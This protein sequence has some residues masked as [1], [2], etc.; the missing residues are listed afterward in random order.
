MCHVLLGRPWQYDI[1]A[2]YDSRKNLITIK[3]D[4]QKL[5]LASLK[6]KEKEVKNLS[7]VKSCI[8]EK[9][10]AEVIPNDGMDLKKDLVNGFLSKMVPN[11]SEVR[12]VV[13]DK[14]SSS[15]RNR[16]DF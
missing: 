2:L 8:V 12:V 9:Q 16:L 15:R 14:M 1:G 3:K 5:T 7:L 4:E 11:G 10:D 13:E 6:E